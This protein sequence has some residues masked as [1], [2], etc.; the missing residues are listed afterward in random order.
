MELS[1]KSGCILWGNRVVVPHQGCQQLLQELHEA[2]PGIS[3]MKSLARLYIWWLGLDQDIKRLVQNCHVCQVNSNTPTS[4]SL[5]PWYWPS[6]P[7]TCIHVDFAG[8]IQGHMLLV[9]IDANT[10]W[11]EYM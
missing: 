2:H 10:K 5:Q 8:P 6:K 3:L 1:L 9:I 7:W 11:M 4:A